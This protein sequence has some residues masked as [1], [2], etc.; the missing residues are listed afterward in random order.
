MSEIKDSSNIVKDGAEELMQGGQQI[1]KEMTILA[2]VTNNLNDSMIDMS[3]NAEKL[4]DIV[5]SVNTITQKNKN[6]MENMEDEVGM[7]KIE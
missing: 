6:N 2:K 4:T 3:M 7:F 1:G 5:S